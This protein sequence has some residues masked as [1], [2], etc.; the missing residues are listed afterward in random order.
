[1][2]TCLD[3]HSGAIGVLPQSSA[4]RQ[5]SEL[6]LE[7][8]Q[9]YFDSNA[10]WVAANEPPEDIDVTLRRTLDA[11]LDKHPEHKH[12]FDNRTKHQCV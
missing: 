9:D 10:A 6:A 12:L 1:M 2:G 3:W 4:E 11:L 7:W 8:R 5:R